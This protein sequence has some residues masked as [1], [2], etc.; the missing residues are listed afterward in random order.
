MSVAQNDKGHLQH[1]SLAT[2][3]TDREI[4]YRKDKSLANELGKE[5]EEDLFE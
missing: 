3:N 2:Y 1:L 5:E 4:K